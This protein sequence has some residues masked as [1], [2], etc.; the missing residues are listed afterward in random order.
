MKLNHIQP[1][2]GIFLL[3]IILSCW[4]PGAA[5][6][7]LQQKTEEA[8]KTETL[9]QLEVDKLNAQV[10]RL[11]RDKKFQ[12]ALPLAQHV[13]ELSEKSVGPNQQQ[14]GSALKNLAA[15]YT[16][17]EKHKE[18]ANS[19]QRLLKLQEKLYGQADLRLCETITSLGYQKLQQKEFGEAENA[20]KRGLKIREAA[21]GPDHLN[22][23][24]DLNGLV[25]VYQQKGSHGEAINQYKRMLGIHEKHPGTDRTNEAELLVKC[26]AVMRV[27][28]RKAEADEY[29]ARARAIYSSVNDK[30]KT[31]SVPGGILQ[32][33][34]IL[35][36]QPGYP[37]E[38]KQA[39][40]QGSVQVAVE[41]DEA[42]IVTTA[43]ATSG[44]NELR[45]ASEDAARKWRFKPTQLEGHPVKVSG[46]LTF[47][48]TLR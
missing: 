4:L 12:E 11:Y 8:S 25:A 7:N 40:V 47:N 3:L 19:Y 34:A 15:V 45:R 13:V 29:E 48:F 27:V 1:R 10:V 30:P 21:Q 43:K 2:V 32:G 18:A 9:E 14:T 42:G 44:P 16:A 37:S 38:A 36:V 17:L 35:K 5:A 28:E 22:L 6:E 41:I 24:P 33:Y 31:V 46:V 20:F 23:I 39:H 26:A